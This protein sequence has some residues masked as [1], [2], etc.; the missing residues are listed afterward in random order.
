MI[1]KAA[2][3]AEARGWDHDMLS[4]LSLAVAIP[5]PQWGIIH[6]VEIYC[7]IDGGSWCFVMLEEFSTLTERSEEVR[8]AVRWLRQ[9]CKPAE[10]DLL[11]EPDCFLRYIGELDIQED[12]ENHLGRAI[13]EALAQMDIAWTVLHLVNWGNKSVDQAIS[14]IQSL[15][16]QSPQST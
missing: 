12:V 7:S 14:Q 4:T 6:S 3:L 16:T 2:D 5:S 11:P 13:D 8:C 10:F 15:D 9:F 1:G